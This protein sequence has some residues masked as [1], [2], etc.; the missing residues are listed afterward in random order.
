M[1][2]PEHQSSDKSS[3]DK[4]LK[5]ILDVA[6]QN[7]AVS[8]QLLATAQ[9]SNDCLHQILDVLESFAHSY[10]VSVE[11]VVIT[12]PKPQPAPTPKR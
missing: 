7:L 12:R 4:I 5:Q 3:T 2:T 11:Q 8:Q 1:P 9:D 6:T 10:S